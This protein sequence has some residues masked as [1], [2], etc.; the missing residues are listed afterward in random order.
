MPK[1]FAIDYNDYFP[2]ICEICKKPAIIYTTGNINDNNLKFS[3]LCE[4][5]HKAYLRK[6]KL[7]KLNELYI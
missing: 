3:T 4:K 7:K 2:L 5:H 6:E 1:H